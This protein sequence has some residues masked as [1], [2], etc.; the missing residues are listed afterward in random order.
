LPA[1]VPLLAIEVGAILGRNA[2]VGAPEAVIGV[3][4]FGASTPGEVMM[5][6]YG[7]TVSPGLAPAYQRSEGNAMSENP[8]FK[9]EAMGRASLWGEQEAP[10]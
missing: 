1:G 5:R 8:L 4:R 3:D 9:L 6:D 2:Y 10:L 7:F